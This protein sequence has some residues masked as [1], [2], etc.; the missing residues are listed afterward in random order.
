MQVLPSTCTLFCKGCEGRKKCRLQ[1]WKCECNQCDGSEAAYFACG[2]MTWQRKGANES[3]CQPCLRK[4]KKEVDIDNKLKNFKKYEHEYCKALKDSAFVSETEWKHPQTGRVLDIYEIESKEGD[5]AS[6]G[7]W[8]N[9]IWES[10]RWQGP[11]PSQ[12]WTWMVLRLFVMDVVGRPGIGP[13]AN[14]GASGR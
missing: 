8:N 1:M 5:N 10:A 6:H 4:N 3:W 13:D 7:K 9:I 11:E 12:C 14:V 2:W